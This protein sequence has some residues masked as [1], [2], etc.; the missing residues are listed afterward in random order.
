MALIPGK[1]LQ[2]SNKSIRGDFRYTGRTLE[3]TLRN[4]GQR[5]HPD[6]CPAI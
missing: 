3:E 1:I 2:L 5:V 4:E 6:F